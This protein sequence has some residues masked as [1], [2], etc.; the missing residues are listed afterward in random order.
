[1]SRLLVNFSQERCAPFES[2]DFNAWAFGV[3]STPAPRVFRSLAPL[4]RVLFR[5]FMESPENLAVPVI[6][7][8]LQNP[9]FAWAGFRPIF[10]QHSL[11]EDVALKNWARG[12]KI[13]VEIGVAEG[14]SALTL[15]SSMLHAGMLYL[16]DPY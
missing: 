16:I 15:N 4:E 14:G 12:R 8:H 3:S 1:M 2:V 10:A 6:Y 13:V 5:P 7:R 9:L 11:A